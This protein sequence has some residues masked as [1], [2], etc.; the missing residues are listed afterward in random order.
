MLMRVRNYGNK[1]LEHYIITFALLW[2]SQAVFLTPLGN[3]WLY[4]AT[5]ASWGIEPAP[6]VC[7]QGSCT[8]CPSTQDAPQTDKEMG[9]E[10]A[11][12]S[13]PCFS[14][15]KGGKGAESSGSL[16]DG[17]I[18]AR[19]PPERKGMNGEASNWLAVFP[20]PPFH[21]CPQRLM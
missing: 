4:G 6:E 12:K 18:W 8:R 7:K 15:Q 1:V 2:A 20:P 9:L 10:V 21:P 17:R 19:V 11:L 3:R 14:L 13:Q 5:F 16:V